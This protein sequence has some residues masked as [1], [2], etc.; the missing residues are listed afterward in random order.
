[1]PHNV[2]PMSDPVR[3]GIAACLLGVV[4]AL[5]G[6]AGPAHAW[7]EGPCDDRPGITVVVDFK[8]FRDEVLVR[9]APAPVESGFD[10]LRRVGLDVTPTQ[11]QPGFLCRIAGLPADD[12]CVNP[13]SADAYWSYW[14]AEHGG[15]WTYS[16][17]GPATPNPPP[18]PVE[19]WA[20]A[21]GGDGPPRTAPPAR[22]PS[23]PEPTPPAPSPE[24]PPEP[25]REAPAP[26]PTPD[27]PEPTSDRGA[28]PPEVSPG[29]PA[30]APSQPAPDPTT[31]ED[32]ASP[33]AAAT[34][35]IPI[36]TTASTASTDPTPVSASPTASDGIAA[37]A[38]VADGGPPAG[39]LVGVALVAVVGAGAV[40]VNRRRRRP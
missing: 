37:V 35:P 11:R 27:P 24:P 38:A 31:V 33:S 36:P 2:A 39:T 25:T 40:V 16:Q 22:E 6:P 18:G 3:R 26:P 15:Q 34:E 7:T 14:R 19:G 17:Y 5:V 12:A 9:C 23:Q 20:F 32:D 21:T 29:D 1:M 13:P 10:A 30:A 4:L 28:A 8:D